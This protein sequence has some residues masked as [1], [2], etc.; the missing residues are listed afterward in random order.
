MAMHGTNR[1]VVLGLV[2]S[3]AVT[4]G[5]AALFLVVRQRSTVPIRV[6]ATIGRGLITA[7]VAGAAAYAASAPFRGASRGAALLALGAG[8]LAWAL[9]TAAVARLLGVP[10]MAEL[11]DLS[12]ARPSTPAGAVS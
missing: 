6:S 4:A 9:A 8:G 7:V 10:E 12:A 5:A 1:V 3:V 2:H 11:R